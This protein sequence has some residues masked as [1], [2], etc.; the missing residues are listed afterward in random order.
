PLVTS[1]TQDSN[2]IVESG[3][4]EGERVIVQGTGKVTPGMTVKTVDAQMPATP[5]S[6][7]Q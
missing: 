6:G 5:A 4:K 2:W 1:G 3:L 7:A